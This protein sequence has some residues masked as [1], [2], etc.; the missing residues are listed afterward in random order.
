MGSASDARGIPNGTRQP[1]TASA[2]LRILGIE[3]TPVARQKPALH[4]WLI[5]NPPTRELDISL[6]RNGYGMVIDEIYGPH[7]LRPTA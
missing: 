4:A 1:A 5:E 2:L 7:R 3:N 6:R